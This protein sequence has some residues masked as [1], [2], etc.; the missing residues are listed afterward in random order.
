MLTPILEDMYISLPGQR[1]PKNDGPVTRRKT[2]PGLPTMW[3][4]MWPIAEVLNLVN[5]VTWSNRQET[6]I[7]IGH[8]WGLFALYSV[9]G[10]DTRSP[11]AA[12]PPSGTPHFPTTAVQA[13]SGSRD[14]AVSSFQ[15]H[16]PQVQ[17]IRDDRAKRVGVPVRKDD[18][19]P[20]QALRKPSYAIPF[21][22]RQCCHPYSY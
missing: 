15:S 12:V 2:A 21:P 1:P 5:L 17:Q 22:E 7:C 9:G 11:H 4:D 14:Y 19:S 6:G 16:R 3:R 18:H 13:K 8:F 10:I 20:S